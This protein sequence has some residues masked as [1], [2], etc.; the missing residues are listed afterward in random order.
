VVPM[1]ISS[2]QGVIR[3]AILAITALCS[4]LLAGACLLPDEGAPE[5]DELGTDQQGLAPALPSYNVNIA[6]TSV[7]GLSSGGFFAGQMGVAFSSIIKGVGV[8]AGGT[9]D[10]AGQMSYASCMYSGTPS[11]TTSISN[12]TSWSGVSI[13]PAS[14]MAAQKVYMF[15]GTSD[16]T[17]ATSV[18][19]QVYKYYVTNGSFVPAGN[20][21]YKKD[22][23]AAHTFPT[24]F[25]STGNNACTTAAS[26]YISN[27]GFDGAGAIL[28]RIYGS[29]NARNTGT[30]GGTVIQFDQTEFI[31]NPN[32]FGMDASGWAY[33]PA[34][35]ASGAQCKLHIAFH[36]CKQNYA[37]I[38]DK[39]IKNTGYNKWADTN[40]IIVLYPQTVADSVNHNPSPSGA[41]ANNNACWDWVGYYGS[42]FDKRS[43][44][45]MAAIK[46]MIDRVSSG[47]GGAPDGGASDGG[48]VVPPAPTGLTSTGT[49][50]STASLSW[51][52]SAGATSYNV[53]RNG[54][55]ANSSAV[56]TTSYTDSGLSAS[57]TYTYAVTAV[58][59]AGESGTSNQVT[60]TTSAAAV[61]YTATNYAHVQA[62]RAHDSIGYAYANG[63]NQNMGLDNVAINTTLKQ[64]GTNYYVIGTC[65]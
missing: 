46:K 19:D 64:T 43:G 38:G 25:S 13:D 8:V 61:C 41:G 20:V 7:S 21:T 55:K 12:T 33:V 4:A 51:G 60:A 10:C 27:C 2:T 30:L 49:T 6:D 44:K 24:D 40:N 9:Y 11:V 48:A 1:K 65:P 58:S 39:F 57:T 26:P 47:Y 62:G 63:S 50:S 31:A 22:L 16:T 54:A 37:A 35:C 29:L 5:G 18:M 32:S 17:V 28:Q 34:A 45:Q 59:S 23:N 56:T 36:G 14:N 3:S 42:D 52:A 53:Y 15:S